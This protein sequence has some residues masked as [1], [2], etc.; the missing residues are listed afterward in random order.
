MAEVFS[1]LGSS[2]DAFPLCAGGA[3]LEKQSPSVLQES[4]LP[5][6]EKKK[7]ENTKTTKPPSPVWVFLSL[8]FL[9]SFL[10]KAKGAGQSET[11]VSAG[12][13]TA[14]QQQQKLLRA[15]PPKH[16]AFISCCMRHHCVFFCRGS[17][18]S[19]LET[20][21]RKTSWRTSGLF[22]PNPD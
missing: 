1:E 5:T 20:G 7:I 6:S 12:C 17:L 13:G 22:S 8:L 10:L 16:R 21:V 2:S 14:V 4:L 3:S 9:I 11:T 18:S 19:S 15:I